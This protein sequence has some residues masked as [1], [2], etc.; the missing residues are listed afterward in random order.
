LGGGF[1]FGSVPDS[2]SSTSSGGFGSANDDKNDEEPTTI[3]TNN[4]SFNQGFSGFGD[5]SGQVPSTVSPFGNNQFSFAAVSNNNNNMSEHEEDD[6]NDDMDDLDM[7]QPTQSVNENPPKSFSSSFS[8]SFAA[9]TS[10]SSSSY[11]NV[12]SSPFS[13]NTQFGRNQTQETQQNQGGRNGK[14]RSMG[15]RFCHGNRITVFKG[16]GIQCLEV[17]DPFEKFVDDVVFRQETSEAFRM[18]QLCRRQCQNMHSLPSHEIIERVNH[19]SSAILNTSTSYRG[20]ISQLGDITLMQSIHLVQILCLSSVSLSSA[21]LGVLLVD[22]VRHTSAD[23]DSLVALIMRGEVERAMR[24]LQSF[25][26]PLAQKISQLLENIPH[27]SFPQLNDQFLFAFEEWKREVKVTLSR[28]DRDED[29]LL[30]TLLQIMSGDMDT[31]STS[32]GTQLDQL[33]ATILYNDP[34]ISLDTLPDVMLDIVERSGGKM[35]EYRIYYPLLLDPRNIYDYFAQVSSSLGIWWS[36]HVYDLIWHSE[37]IKQ[38][39]GSLLS[40][41]VFEDL[42]DMRERLLSEYV[43]KLVSKP[44]RERT[45]IMY[46]MFS[47][48]KDLLELV[49]SMIPLDSEKTCVRVIDECRKMCQ[50]FGVEGKSDVE[51][52]VHKILAMQY[53]KQK[54]NFASGIRH[55]LIAQDK[56]MIEPVLRYAISS[57]LDTL[58]LSDILYGGSMGNIFSLECVSATG[59]RGALPLVRP[60]ELFVAYART[61]DIENLVNIFKNYSESF[62]PDKFR[63]MII[64]HC[65]YVLETENRNLSADDLTLL[66]SELQDVCMHPVLNQK[67]GKTRDC[68]TMMRLILNEKLAE[69]FLS[70]V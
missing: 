36:L 27:F 43:Q 54:S 2:S 37:H 4:T 40:S 24:E 53:I 39:N 3:T 48:R 33:A 10:F 31:I 19:W 57:Y 66:M 55:L 62:I 52:S 8:S 5:S 56:K 50:Y 46:A 26:S 59:V 65:V 16:S 21:H 28:A 41:A 60:Y 14:V 17:V 61:N 45:A 63:A 67:E 49:L 12:T 35:G 18:L 11:A 1:N 30:L 23:R 7:N 29:D 13:T 38:L 44:G 42:T 64:A 47:I 20:F 9:P 22:W 25:K 70:K 68:I 32:E 6:S 34:I 58:E 51:K 15:V 69:A